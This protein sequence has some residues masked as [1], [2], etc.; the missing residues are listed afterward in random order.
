M[1]AIFLDPGHY[2]DTIH[3]V[4]RLVLISTIP[5]FNEDKVNF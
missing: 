1:P 4:N 2:L 3:K 5:H